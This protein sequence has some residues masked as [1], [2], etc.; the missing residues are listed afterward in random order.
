M[1]AG[2]CVWISAIALSS[3][4]VSSSEFVLGCLVTVIRTAGLPRSEATP[5]F[6]VLAPVR[7]SATCSSRIGLPPAVL[8]TAFPMSSAEVVE[9][10]PRMMYSLPYWFSTPPFELRLR[11]FTTFITSS[12][13][14]LK[15]FMR[16]G[17]SRIWYSRI[18]PPM[19]VTCATPPVESSRGRMFQSA[20]VRSSCSEVLSEVRPTIISSPRIDDC[21]PRVGFPTLSGSVALTAANFS[22]TIWRAL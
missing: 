16:I 14:T 21:G 4:S 13:E 18:S 11:S 20:M 1:S 8:T 10:M 5:I 12:S 9:S 15:F 3:R 22:E 19:T 17:S 6:G 7:T 2:S